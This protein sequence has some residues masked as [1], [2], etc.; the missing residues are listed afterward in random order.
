MVTGAIA[1]AI[2]VVQS[3]TL[4]TGNF[5][6]SLFPVVKVADSS[7]VLGVEKKSEA[8]GVRSESEHANQMEE[9][10]LDDFEVNYADPDDDFALD[11][12]GDPDDD[13]SIGKDVDLNNGF[14][15]G[16]VTSPENSSTLEKDSGPK[17]GYLLENSGNPTVYFASN[18]VRKSDIVLELEKVR[19]S[20]NGFS[21]PSGSWSTNISDM[22][23]SVLG[24]LDVNSTS[25]EEQAGLIHPVGESSGPFQSVSASLSGNSTIASIP[26]VRKRAKRR[27]SIPEMSR[28]LL[29]NHD[30]SHSMKPRWSSARDRE[31][32]SAKMQ[33]ENASFVKI[34]HELHGPVFLNVSVFQR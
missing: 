22:D 28:L 8:S 29:R 19:S 23:G 15:S 12:D 30:S 5:F 1:A 9:K 6:S 2:L 24:K 3:L 31:L 32:L 17:N 7:V 20:G 10:H 13:F 21:Y 18:N 33:I 4:P 34:D 11:D 27:I 25:H 16:V 14:T 26:A